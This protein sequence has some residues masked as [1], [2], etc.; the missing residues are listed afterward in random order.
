MWVCARHL[1]MCV[2][3]LPEWQGNWKRWLISRITSVLLPQKKWNTEEDSACSSNCGFSFCQFECL[4]CF[5][6]LLTNLEQSG[7]CRCGTFSDLKTK[8]R[9]KDHKN[10]CEINRLSKTYYRE[11]GTHTHTHT[12]E[13]LREQKEN[14]L[15]YNNLQWSSTEW[16]LFDVKFLLFFFFIYTHAHPH[17]WERTKEDAPQEKKDD[18]LHFSPFCSSTVM[19]FRQSNLTTN[20]PF[21]SKFST[22]GLLSSSFSILSLTS[23]RKRS[24]RC[25]AKATSVYSA[26]HWTPLIRASFQKSHSCLKR[27]TFRQFFFPLEYFSPSKIHNLKQNKTQSIYVQ[28][29]YTRELIRAQKMSYKQR[30]ESPTVTLT[31]HASKYKGFKSTSGGVY[32]PC[33]YSHARWEWP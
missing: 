27:N 3:T 5:S 32:V 2:Y 18:A 22:I 30:P 17:P 23:W 10:L 25:Q 29:Q 31:W 4:P 33:I 8:T 21:F 12:H 20:K 15:L 16:C 6:W 9:L 1:C 14:R 28:N 13:N 24:M 19:A 26:R 7:L 11:T